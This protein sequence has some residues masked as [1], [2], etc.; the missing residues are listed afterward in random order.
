MSTQ[1]FPEYAY[2]WVRTVVAT[3]AGDA[4][5][6][7]TNVSK[8]M[9]ISALDIVEGVGIDFW[10]RNQIALE[11]LLAPAASEVATTANLAEKSCND[12]SVWPSCR[13]S[14]RHDSRCNLHYLTK[15]LRNN[16]AQNAILGA[17]EVA[18]VGTDTKRAVQ[19]DCSPRL[20]VNKSLDLGAR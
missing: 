5:G 18:G 9:R 8:S 14:N 6:T 12:C 20:E 4:L 15:D 19:K 3:G 11:G 13:P 16:Q 1:I 17:D 2:N 7:F 10:R